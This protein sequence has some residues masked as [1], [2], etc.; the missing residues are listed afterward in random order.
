[1]ILLLAAAA[2][3]PACSS[4]SPPPR[5]AGAAPCPC[6]SP[7]PGQPDSGAPVATDAAAGEDVISEAHALWAKLRVNAEKLAA[8]GPDDPNRGWLERAVDS[9]GRVLFQALSRPEF[10]P[11][12]A[13][14]GEIRARLLFVIK[15]P[16]AEDR[17]EAIQFVDR[18]F[19]EIQK[20]RGRAAPAAASPPASS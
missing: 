9:D 10:E 7:A 2:L 15:P 1:L 14:R 18:G 13:I 19:G 4:P 5:A 6:P 16:P 8:A 17:R 3:G 12:A 11:Y 20:R